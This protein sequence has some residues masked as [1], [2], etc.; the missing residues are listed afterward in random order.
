[1]APPRD[2]LAWVRF[3]FLLVQYERQGMPLIRQA[4]SAALDPSVCYRTSYRVTRM[5]WTDARAFGSQHWVGKFR[6][7]ILLPLRCRQ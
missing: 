2:V 6:E 7:D 4:W 5:P 3:L 1:M